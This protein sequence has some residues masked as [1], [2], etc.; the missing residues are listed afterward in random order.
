[1]HGGEQTTKACCVRVF[2]VSVCGRGRGAPGWR[3]NTQANYPASP[4][5]SA[6]LLSGCLHPGTKHRARHKSH[7]ARMQTWGRGA[8]SAVHRPGCTAVDARLLFLACY[9]HLASQLEQFIEVQIE[10]QPHWND[11]T[12]NDIRGVVDFCLTSDEQN[13][14]SSNIKCKCWNICFFDTCHLMLWHVVWWKVLS[15]KHVKT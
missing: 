9:P 11:L 10:T 8:W 14:N 13:P 3:T 1:M 15:L 6:A 7:T 4:W 2:T 5:V 12:A